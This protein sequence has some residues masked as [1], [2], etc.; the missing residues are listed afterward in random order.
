[1]IALRYGGG[2]GLLLVNGR[3][4]PEAG[5]SGESRMNMTVRQTKECGREERITRPRGQEGKG[6]GNQNA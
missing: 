6:P 1:M 2:K 5:T 3:A 4:Q